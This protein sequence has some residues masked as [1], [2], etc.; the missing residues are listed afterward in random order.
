M[1]DEGE[2]IQPRRL[3]ATSDSFTKRSPTEAPGHLMTDC[4][5]LL[6]CVGQSVLKKVSAIRTVWAKFTGHEVATA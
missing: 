1:T 2:I 6:K 5:S 3:K 4:R